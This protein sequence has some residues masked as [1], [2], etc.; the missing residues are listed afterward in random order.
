MR[1]HSPA[2]APNAEPPTITGVCCALG[3]DRTAEIVART[4]FSCPGT[5][6]D[7]AT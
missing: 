6:A 7:T 3:R 1:F 4:A 5:L 2:S